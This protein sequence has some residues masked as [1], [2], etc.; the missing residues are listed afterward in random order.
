M[1][2]NITGDN[3]L[4][5]YEVNEAADYIFSKTQGEVNIIFGVVIDEKMNGVIQAMIIATDFSDSLALKSS[6]I[7]PI[8]NQNANDSQN[9]NY[10]NPPVSNFQQNKNPAPNSI[11]PIFNFNRDN[12]NDK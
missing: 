4:S 2:L 7:L 1:I 8:Q 10:T 3:E 9:F 5:L 11:I 6:Q 12:N